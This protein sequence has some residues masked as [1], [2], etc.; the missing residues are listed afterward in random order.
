MSIL[1]NIRTSINFTNN[2]KEIL[3][4]D[5]TTHN[6]ELSKTVNTAEAIVSQT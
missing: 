2:Q 1:Q 4:I 5:C 3:P 6:R